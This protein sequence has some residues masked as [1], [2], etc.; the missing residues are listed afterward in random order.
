MRPPWGNTSGHTGTA[1]TTLRN[2]FHAIPH[3]QNTIYTQSTQTT[4]TVPRAI[5]PN[6]TVGANIRAQFSQAKCV[7]AV[8]MCPPERPRSGVSIGKIYLRIT[9]CA[10]G[11]NDGCALAGRHGRAHRRRPYPSPSCLSVQS[12]HNQQP[13][14]PRS[15]NTIHH[16][17]MNERKSSTI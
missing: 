11:F 15:C 9:H 1:P 4:S 14:R 10:R 6:E 7:G 16:L 17:E 12:T 2:I 8:P 5:C 13:L 3:K